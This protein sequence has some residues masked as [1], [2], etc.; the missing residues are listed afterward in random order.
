MVY[1]V[2]KKCE[3]SGSSRSGYSELRLQFHSFNECI[4]PTN[5]SKALQNARLHLVD[6]PVYANIGNKIYSTANPYSFNN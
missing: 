5:V 2:K 3:Q 1:A 6:S 4:N